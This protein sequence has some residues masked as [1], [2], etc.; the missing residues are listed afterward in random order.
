MVLQERQARR[1]TILDEFYHTNT[2]L[3]VVWKELH[4]KFYCIY[5]QFLSY[6]FHWGTC[7]NRNYHTPSTTWICPMCGQRYTYYHLRD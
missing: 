4:F 5:I 2:M 7:T 1:L 3:T 6:D